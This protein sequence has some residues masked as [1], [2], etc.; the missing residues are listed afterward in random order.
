MTKRIN[1]RSFHVASL[2]NSTPRVSH[3]QFTRLSLF[4]RADTFF[5]SENWLIASDFHGSFRN[6]LTVLFFRILLRRLT[7]AT[8]LFFIAFPRSFLSSRF[9]RTLANNSSSSMPSWPI[10]RGF[11]WQ[12]CPALSMSVRCFFVIDHS[13]WLSW[14]LTGNNVYMM[15]MNDVP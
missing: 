7:D 6:A 8:P 5:I 14:S 1:R 3:L 2:A 15:T 4:R 9:W 12:T 13:C 11:E 10:D